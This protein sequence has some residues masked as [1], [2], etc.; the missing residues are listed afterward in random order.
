M[1]ALIVAA[2]A[3]SPPPATPAPC[4]NM[5]Q[6][7]SRIATESCNTY[8][9]TDAATCHIYKKERSD[10]GGDS[11]FCDDPVTRCAPIP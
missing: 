1:I 5:G 3:T 7:A 11:W 6:F 4:D 10:G 9:L 8:D 2:T